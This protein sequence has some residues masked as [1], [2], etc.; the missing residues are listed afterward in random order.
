MQTFFDLLVRDIERKRLP[1]NQYYI[2]AI[3]KTKYII[4]NFKLNIRVVDRNWSKKEI[5]KYIDFKALA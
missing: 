1:N 2:I 5:I 3:F 4:L